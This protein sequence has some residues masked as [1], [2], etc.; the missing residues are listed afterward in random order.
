[1]QQVTQD[2]RRAGVAGPLARFTEPLLSGQTQ[3]ALQA[4]GLISI[5]SDQH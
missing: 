2:N 1:M 5:S 3:A 4:A